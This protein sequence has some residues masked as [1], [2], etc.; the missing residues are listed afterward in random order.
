MALDDDG[1]RDRAKDAI[2]TLIERD[3]TFT[4]EDIRELAG[5]P[6]EPNDLGP[7][8][9]TAHKRKIIERVGYQPATRASRAGSI[10]AVWTVHPHRKPR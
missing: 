10:N 3:A 4:A 5:D 7:I 9:M 2:Q 6:P 1:W 8:L